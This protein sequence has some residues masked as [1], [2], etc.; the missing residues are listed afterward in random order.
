MT[1]GS[2]TTETRLRVARPT[3]AVAAQDNPSLSEGV[4]SLSVIEQTTGLYRCEAQI[5]NW[6]TTDGTIGFLYFDRRVL[7]FGKAFAVKIGQDTVFDGRITGLEA[8]FP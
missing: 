2:G 5:G 7:D 4:I 3:L 6:G 8:H 1:D